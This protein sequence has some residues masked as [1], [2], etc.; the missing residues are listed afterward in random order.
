[1]LLQMSEAAIRASELRAAV[2][3]IRDESM[4]IGDPQQPAA[5]CEQ[6]AVRPYWFRCP[7]CNFDWREWRKPSIIFVSLSF[8]TDRCPNCRRKNVRACRA[9]LDH[10]DGRQIEAG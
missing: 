3:D 4:S 1:M 7:T 10:K 5:S 8:I 6:H 9:G 2:I